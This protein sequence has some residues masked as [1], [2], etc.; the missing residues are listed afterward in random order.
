MKQKTLFIRNHYIYMQIYKKLSY[1]NTYYILDWYWYALYIILI[2]V[3]SSEIMRARWQLSKS[4]RFWCTGY[5]LRIN[6]CGREGS[7]KEWTKGGIKLWCHPDSA[8]ANLSGP[9]E[10]TWSIWIILPHNWNFL[11][12]PC[13]QFQSSMGCRLL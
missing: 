3:F 7:K 10:S 5:L 2:W 11:T 12:H 13:F 6:T 8:S 9:S 4:E 1:Q